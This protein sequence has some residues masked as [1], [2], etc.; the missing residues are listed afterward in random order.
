M[1]HDD[2]DN[3][4]MNEWEN[5]FV[6]DLY[7]SHLFWAQKIVVLFRERSFVCPPLQP[8]DLI[9]DLLLLGYVDGWLSG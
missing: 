4:R 6:V 1:L 9:I 5:V 3:A 8:F 2:I 7:S